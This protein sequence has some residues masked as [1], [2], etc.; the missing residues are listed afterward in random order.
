M[1]ACHSD[2]A[3]PTRGLGAAPAAARL[4]GVISAALRDGGAVPAA[5]AGGPR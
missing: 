3:L 4:Q 5:E 1:S 2:G